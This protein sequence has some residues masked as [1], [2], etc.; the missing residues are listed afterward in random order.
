MKG[1][2][3]A[4]GSAATLLVFIG[5]V[6]A[7]ARAQ[8]P[9]DANYDESKVGRYAPLDPLTTADGRKVTTPDL[10]TQV[11]RPELLRLFETEMYGRVP[12]P[13]E[14]I[15]PV[16]RVRSEDRQAL[17]GKAV[18]R[19]VTIAFS[20]RPDGP[21]MDLLIYLPKDPGQSGRVP[22]FLGLN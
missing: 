12:Q 2:L 1:P 17:D 13:P 3:H 15:R 4:A 7:T 11:R 20:D 16:Y 10:W 6:A 8:N 14:P 5:S 21:R 18:R 22:A 9:P 19:E